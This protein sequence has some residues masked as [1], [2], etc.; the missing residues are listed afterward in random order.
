[1]PRCPNCGFIPSAQVDQVR[2]PNGMELRCG[3]CRS[4]VR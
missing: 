1:M 3:D 4:V 2:S